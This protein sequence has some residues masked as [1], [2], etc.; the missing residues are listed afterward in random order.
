ME[1][2]KKLG[3]KK[4]GGGGVEGGK[5]FELRHGWLE[6]KLDD[7]SWLVVFTTLVDFDFRWGVWTRGIA[8]GVRGTF[9]YVRGN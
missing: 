3:G 7:I 6:R 1:R 2:L 5:V 8:G 4:K 9:Q